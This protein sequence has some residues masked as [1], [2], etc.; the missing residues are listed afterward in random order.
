[1]S[2]SVPQAVFVD[3]ENLALRFA[4]EAQERGEQ[5]SALPGYREG[6]YVWSPYLQ[7]FF[8]TRCPG[9]PIHYFTSTRGGEEAL[10]ALES[11]MKG[12]G[13]R[14]HVRHRSRGRPAKGVDLSLALTCD[15]FVRTSG[16]REVALVTGDGD[17]V[18]L[19]ERLQDDFCDVR[20]WALRSGL[21]ADLR[22]VATQVDDEQLWTELA[23]SFPSGEVAETPDVTLSGGDLGG[24]SVPRGGW[25]IGEVQT[26]E[27]RW[28]YRLDP[29]GLSAVYVGRTTGER[30]G[31]GPG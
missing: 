21:S 1:M 29:P 26:F 23:K 13:L 4:T 11:E 31:G 5:A 15:R 8:N 12:L 6:T 28:R 10:I 16:A 25:K 18:P 2:R 24:A 9:A 19:V 27:K 14:P 7:S 3:G 22:R 17:F 20:V 30:P